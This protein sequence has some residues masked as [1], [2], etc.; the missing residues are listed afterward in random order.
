MRL[1]VRITALGS[2]RYN[3]LHLFVVKLYCCLKWPKINE[4][5]LEFP[6]F[7]KYQNN[8]NTNWGDR[9]MVNNQ[10]RAREIRMQI[11]KVFFFK[12]GPFPASFFF[13]FIFSIQLTVYKC[14]INFA[15]DWIPTADLWYWKQPLYQLS[16]N[17]CLV[18]K[19]F[20]IVRD[21]RMNEK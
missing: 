8:H 18:P 6:I 16:H 15:K 4:K 20:N 5:S 11:P 1:Q 10:C 3:V 17:H 2:R 19:V 14:S 12:N 21:R 13:I 9:E 7:I